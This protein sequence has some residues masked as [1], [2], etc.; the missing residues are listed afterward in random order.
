MSTSKRVR[1]FLVRLGRGDIEPRGCEHNA[2]YL[3]VVTLFV[4]LVLL[5]GVP[6]RKAWAAISDALSTMPM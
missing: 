5:I 2:V 3:L 4:G 1:W 6:I